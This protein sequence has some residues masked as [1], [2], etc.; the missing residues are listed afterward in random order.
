MLIRT[1]LG[2]SL[3]SSC[4]GYLSRP[5]PAGHQTKSQDPLPGEL[6]SLKDAVSEVV[7]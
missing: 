4:R 2:P 3:Q 1:L 5:E 7:L 6:R